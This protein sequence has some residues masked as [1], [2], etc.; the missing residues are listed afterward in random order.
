[1]YNLNINFSEICKK[2]D[3]RREIFKFNN[4]FHAHIQDCR[5]DSINRKFEHVD[6]CDDK[7]LVRSKVTNNSKFDFVFRFYQYA[8]AWMRIFLEKLAIERVIDIERVMSLI[9]IRYLEITVFSTKIIKMKV[10]INVCDIDNALHECKSYVILDF[11]F[12]DVI[13]N[14]KVREHMRREFH[15]MND[16]KCK[17]L[18]SLNIMISEETIINFADKTLIISIC[19]NMIV[20]IR[21]NFKSNSQIRR[22]MHSKEFVVILFNFV[23]NISIYMREKTLFFDRNFLFE[24]LERYERSLHSRMRLQFNLR[25][26]SQWSF[27]V[28]DDIISLTLKH[29]HEIRRERLLSNRIWISRMSSRAQE[30]RT[31]E[32][33]NDFLRDLKSRLI[34]KRA[35]EIFAML[36][37]H[38][39][40]FE[41]TN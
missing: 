9:D 3:K 2:C 22:V 27:Q 12:D 14:N 28:S 19:E 21:I 30:K 34:L 17:L 24:H 18:M 38:F 33:S 8:T 40:Q 35:R 16:L 4:V 7:S 6:D 29:D 1:M 13:E 5:V 25:A 36:V 32:F 15:I 11:Y 23:M 37:E 26:C 10:V 31:C 39:N 20:S 41:L